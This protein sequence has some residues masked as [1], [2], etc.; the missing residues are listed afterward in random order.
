[1]LQLAETQ[2]MLQENL[3]ISQEIPLLKSQDRI[4]ETLDRLDFNVSYFLVGRLKASEI[5]PFD[6]YK[7]QFKQDSKVPYGIPFYVDTEDHLSFTLR[8]EDP[9]WSDAVND[10]LLKFNQPFDLGGWLGVIQRISKKW[11]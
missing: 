9:T 2:V 1:M 11:Q 10:K 4:Q 8:T 3:Q 6:Y 7:V 5:Y